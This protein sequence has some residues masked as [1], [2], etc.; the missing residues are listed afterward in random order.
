MDGGVPRPTEPQ[1]SP[2]AAVGYL[3]SGF[4]ALPNADEIQAIQ[5]CTPGLLIQFIFHISSVLW[6]HVFPAAT[7]NHLR[8]KGAITPR[9]LDCPEAPGVQAWKADTRVWVEVWT[10]VQPGKAWA[11]APSLNYL[12][13]LER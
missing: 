6:V 11:R 1:L 7:H 8:D 12:F 10:V 13:R 2:P 9:A 5:P 3:V 4:K